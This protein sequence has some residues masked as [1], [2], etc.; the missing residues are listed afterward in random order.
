MLTPREYKERYESI[1]VPLENG[2]LVP[3]KVNQY[4]LSPGTFNG[5]AK[6]FF[7]MLK[8]RGIDM[9][10][11]IDTGQGL[12]FVDPRVTQ[13]DDATQKR[14]RDLMLT[15]SGLQDLI[16]LGGSPHDLRMSRRGLQRD[17]RP[18]GAGL[19][20]GR[21][22]PIWNTRYNTRIFDEKNWTKLAQLVFTGKGSPEACQVV[23]QLAN[24]WGLAPD[25]QAYAD[26]ALGLDCN[27]FVGNYIWHVQ[28][29]NPWM[30]LGAGNHD[31]GPDSPIQTGFYDHYQGHLLDRWESLDTNRKYIMMEAR[32][33]DGV[34]INGGHGAQDTGHIVITQPNLRDNRP[35]KDG[36]MSF[37]VRVVESTAS[38]SPGLWESWYT[39]V[40]YDNKTKSFVINREDMAPA[41]R[42]IH[43]KIAA[44]S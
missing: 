1:E 10:L 21:F 23:L 33:E 5:T 18:L 20:D 39:C 11:R 19:A 6:A 25:V 2:N 42:E 22:R 38:H 26:S 8:K 28:H 7:D 37:A 36:K 43:F 32:K 24:H 29:G 27:G 12:E 9:A 4:R 35:G 41:R 17:V 34:V 40:S 30:K 16:L 44:V 15:G 13:H 3:V 14:R 31:L